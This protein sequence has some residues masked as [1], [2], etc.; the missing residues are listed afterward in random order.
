MPDRFLDNFFTIFHTLFAIFNVFGWIW[1]KTRKIN[2]LLLLLTAFSWIILGIWYGIGYC[3]LTEYHWQVRYR[4][5]YH[6]MPY[7][8]IKFL[9]DIWTGLDW[10]PMVVD[11]ITALLFSS[12]LFISVFLNFKDWRK[13]RAS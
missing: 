9:L 1:T 4:L 6:D 11:T 3:P 10:N 7:S 13:E 5:G 12:A 8:Y 2:L